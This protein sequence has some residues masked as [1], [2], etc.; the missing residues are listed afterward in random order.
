MKTFL[1]SIGGLFLALAASAQVRVDL[2]VDQRQFLAGEDVMVGVRIENFSGQTLR[3]GG[4]DE[5]VTI[6]FDPN[7]K[8]RAHALGKLP[9]GDPFSVTNATRVTRWFNLSPYYDLGAQG[10]YTFSASVRIKDWNEERGTPPVAI[11]LVRG[12]TMWEKVFGVPPAPGAPPGPPELRK[13]QLQRANIAGDMRLYL[14]VT[15]PEEERIRRA[16]AI[17]RLLTLNEPPMP[18][19]D[20]LSRLHVL[21]RTGRTSYN[22]SVFTPDGTQVVRQ[23]HDYNEITGSKPVLRTMDDGE[24]IIAGGVRKNASTDIPPSRPGL[25]P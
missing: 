13:Y 20:R 6:L 14:R 1:T 24:I 18:V 7:S 17:D 22:Y 16:M 3:F 21:H 10:E 23:R 19:I 25:T 12:M 15:D 5:W 2:V 11:E 4:P 8:T 9:G